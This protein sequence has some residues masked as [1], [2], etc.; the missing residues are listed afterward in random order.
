[1]SELAQ[2]YAVSR[3]TIYDIAAKGEQVLLAGL[4]PGP[5]RR[6]LSEKVIR[7]DRNRLARGSVVLTEVGVSQ[8]DVR[9]CLSELLDTEP[10][11]SWVNAE[12]A[13]VERV[14]G[15]VNQGWQPQL[16]ESLSGDEIY[17]N[18]QPKW[19]IGSP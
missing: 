9:L 18:G 17:A 14:A 6:H 19:M 10:S 11:P 16:E 5:H 13:Q 7:V 15:A 8:R 3:K 12:L 2:T 1:M 4:Q